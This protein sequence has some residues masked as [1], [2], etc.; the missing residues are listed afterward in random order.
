MV[1]LQLLRLAPVGEEI[2]EK[3]SHARGAKCSLFPRF[4]EV[5]HN[6]LWIRVRE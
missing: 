4:R 5:I 6:I 1:S 3:L 2:H